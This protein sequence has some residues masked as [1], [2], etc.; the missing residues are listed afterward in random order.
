MTRLSPLSPAKV[1]PSSGAG[2]RARLATAVPAHQD[3]QQ[4]DETAADQLD[5]ATIYRQHAEGVARWA[6][7]LAGPGFDIE[8]IVHE[9]FLVAQRRLPEWRG[10]AKI[11]TWLYEITVR[12]VQGRRRRQRLLRLFSRPDARPSV[13]DELTEIAS[14]EP[15]PLR[16]LERREATSV[17]YQLLEGLGEKY[18]TVLILFELEGLSGEQVA[19]ITGCS[20]TNVWVRLF[21]GREKL[22]ER[23]LAW[24][25]KGGR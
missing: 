25:A 14:D 17:L 1:A 18:R 6:R 19:E 4:N 5:L 9:V 12:V 23:Y 2:V 3:D 13:A 21:R 22:L 20:L 24:E 8:D 15:N 11:T 7:R 10:Q 16:L